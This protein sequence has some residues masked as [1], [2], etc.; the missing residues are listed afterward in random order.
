MNSLVKGVPSV[1]KP[2]LFTE[3]PS[4]RKR[5]SGEVAPLMPTP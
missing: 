3:M 4:M 1:P 5:F 2:G